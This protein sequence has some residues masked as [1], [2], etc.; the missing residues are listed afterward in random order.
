MATRSF[1]YTAVYE[2]DPETGDFIATFPALDLAT[3]GHSLDEARDMAREALALHLEGLLEEGMPIPPDI[4]GQEA[5]QV[6]VAAPS[7]EGA[8]A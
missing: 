3:H 8:R 6:E 2:H 1:T 7:E 4:T 5:I